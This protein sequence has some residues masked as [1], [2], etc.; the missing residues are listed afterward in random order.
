V[1]LF[2]LLIEIAL[3]GESGESKAARDGTN[4]PTELAAFDWLID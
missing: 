4:S 3:A 1:P 2:G